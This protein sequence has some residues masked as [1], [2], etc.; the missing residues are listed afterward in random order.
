MATILFVTK[1]PASRIAIPVVARLTALG[2]ATPIIAEGLSSDFW[3]KEGVPLYFEGSRIPHKEERQLDVVQVL[4]DLTPD[5]IVVCESRP[6]N[7]EERFAQIGN[8]KGIPVIFLEDFWAGFERLDARP[9]L[10][11]T[12]D[13]YACALVQERREDVRIRDVGNPFISESAPGEVPSDLL[14]VVNEW[15]EENGL[16]VVYI[17]GETSSDLAL[18]LESLRKTKGFL[19]PRL[20]PKH[21]ITTL[22]NGITRGEMHRSL[23]AESGIKTLWLDSYQTEEVMQAGDIVCSGLSLSLIT[24]ATLR[25]KTVVLWTP[26]VQSLLARVV[27][28]SASPFVELGIAVEIRGPT[29]FASI[30]FSNVSNSMFKPYRPEQV[31]NEILHIL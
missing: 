7:L 22:Q 6:A 31:V 18:C 4:D 9:D 27:G 17:G 8:R 29:N 26:E 5:A 24:A 19:I 1:D 2:H 16:A 15:K 21:S 13:S 23:I 20:H 10:I 30:P 3:K 12:I 11:C 28:L 25:K 14:R